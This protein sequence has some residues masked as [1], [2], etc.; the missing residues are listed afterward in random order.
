L[1]VTITT[2]NN[3]PLGPQDVTF[4]N[5]SDGGTSTC[6]GCFSI[7]GPT[8][9]TFMTP[10][11]VNGDIVA[12]FSQP[13]GGVSSSNSLVKLTGTST[14]FPTT[15]SCANTSGIPV[16][17]SG[18]NATKAFLHPTALI[19]PGQHYTVH[20]AATG[21]PAVTDF[22]GRT[23]AEATKD[24]QG[25][26][27]QQGE[28]PASLS[29][30]R[31]FGNV[32]A[33]GQT[34]TADHLAGA[35]AAIGFSGT[36]IT[37]FTNVGP[38]Y[39]IADLYIDGVIKATV[40]CY[41]SSNAYRA[42]FTVAGLSPGPHMF[43]IRV[44]GAKGSTQGTGT[45][46]ALDA[47]RVNGKTVNSPY[48]AYTWGIAKTTSASGGAYIRADEDSAVTLFKFRGT[49]IEWDTVLGPG[50]G[51]AKVFIDGVFKGTV[52]NYYATAR[53]NFARIYGGLTDSIH[54]FKIEVLE[55][56]RPAANGS[57]I[58]IDRWVVT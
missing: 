25:G 24:F 39:G 56:H 26:L 29:T 9:V 55:R 41:R 3:A 52:D 7:T 10:L 36:Y 19:T 53:Y 46:I 50:M 18:G 8:T 15:V 17:C 34:Y 1:K 47:Y 58:A 6:A 57:I 12:T 38:A 5:P 42:A 31:I 49:Q 48:A 16:S 27:I 43:V 22:G 21:T 35:T 37:W 2:A 14:T 30:W 13:V 32:N 33:L 51:Q 28:S 54:T 44:R 45:L 4:K 23:V 20:I 40:N 11:T